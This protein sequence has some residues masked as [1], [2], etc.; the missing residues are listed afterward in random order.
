MSRKKKPHV[1]CMNE[2]DWWAD[3]SLQ[4]AKEH[5]RTYCK[6]EIG[7]GDGEIEI[8]VA[9][10]LNKTQLK[11]YTFWQD[12]EIRKGEAITFKEQLRRMAKKGNVPG[13]FA[14]TEY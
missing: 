11:Q 9:Y 10:R 4:E 1:Y 12:E 14:S 5:Y 13:F 6:E 7:I 8:D 3:Y 2:C